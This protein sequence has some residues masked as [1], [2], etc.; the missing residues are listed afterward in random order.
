MRPLGLFAAFTAI[1]VLKCWEMP[2][3]AARHLMTFYPTV[4]ALLGRAYPNIWFEAPSRIAS[5]RTS[6]ELNFGAHT[7]D[8]HQETVRDGKT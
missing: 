7:L 4:L 2:P 5:Q 1:A 3:Y 8:V 6:I